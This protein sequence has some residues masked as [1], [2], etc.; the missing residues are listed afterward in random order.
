M[1]S[2]ILVF[3]SS[4]LSHWQAYV[5]GGAITGLVALVERLL[6]WKMPKWA[7][8][9]LYIG[10]FLL[11]AFFLAWRDQYRVALDVPTL[12]QQIKD[13]DDAIAE[14][15]SH[16]PQITIPPFP[17]PQVVLPS[18]QAFMT[19]YD[20]ELRGMEA[21][22]DI[23]IFFTNANLSQQVPALEANVAHACAVVETKV[24]PR[25][26]EMVV[27]PE[28]EDTAFQRFLT[29]IGKNKK[30]G[31]LNSYG[32]GQTTWDNSLCRPWTTDFDQQLRAQ[33]KTFLHMVEYSWKDG[34]GAHINDVCEWIQPDS[35]LPGKPAVWHFCV[36]HN[37]MRH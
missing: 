36:H 17:A 14:L 33:S 10:I 21:N 25:K 11:V 34:A 28:Y 4:V 16:P 22:T 5:T 7:Y 31:G 37:G 3:V 1:W 15:K 32:P 18:Q 19:E 27:P 29:F 8:A 13:K 20:R 23:Q 24:G 2:D 9:A 6:D 35:F 30:I 12:R 26:P